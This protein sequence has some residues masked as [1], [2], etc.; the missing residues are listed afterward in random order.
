MKP[1]SE[2]RDGGDG[3]DAEPRFGAVPAGRPHLPVVVGVDGSRATLP[4]VDLAVREAALVR[5]PLHIVHVWPGHYTGV[6]R[7]REALP[8]RAEGKRLLQMCAERAA[9]AG[10]DVP[11]TTEL[12]DGDVVETLAGFS[13][14]AA[15]MVV[16]DG[17]D[18][19]A[20]TGWGTT[21]ATLARSTGCPLLVY[22]GRVPERGPVVVAVSIRPGCS[23][24][25]EY[26]FARAELLGTRLV[27]V[28]STSSGGEQVIGRRSPLHEAERALAEVLAEW[29]AR[30]PGLPVDRVVVPEGDVPYL[31]VRASRRSRLL[32][33]GSGRGSGV[34][35]VLFGLSGLGTA[36]RAS[37]PVLF[38]PSS[39]A[40]TTVVPATRESPENKSPDREPAGPERSDPAGPERA[41]TVE[42]A[43]D[44]HLSGVLRPGDSGPTP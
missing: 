41:G 24:T 37:A 10:L 4:T 44:H 6:F 34:P 16:G 30:Y 26:A 2:P 28:H 31:I 22:R 20:G 19:L 25:V 7:G 18:S 15:M 13:G 27:A 1:D 33:A 5:A 12:L 32:V 35:P 29:T 42:A 8:S 23:A 11:I 9:A 21:A 39:P 38:V 14:Q 36:R 17:G 40:S 3:R 43:H